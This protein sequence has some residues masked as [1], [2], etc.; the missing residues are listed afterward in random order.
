MAMVTALWLLALL[1]SLTAVALAAAREGLARSRWRTTRVRADP[2]RLTL[3]R[4]DSI[5]LGRGTWCTI[6]AY[7]PAAR[8][9]LNL[10]DSAM[11]RSY[12][13]SDSLVAALLDWRDADDVP[14]R[15]GA[16]RREY[17]ALDRP[18]PRNGALE[19]VSE[20]RLVRGF[21]GWSADSLRSVWTVDGDGR[22]DVNLAPMAMLRTLPWFTAGDLM[23]LDVARARGDRVGDLYSFIALLGVTRRE[24]LAPL[25]PDI[26]HALVTS[27]GALAVE[28]TAG[29]AGQPGVAHNALTVVPQSGRLAVVR[30]VA[31]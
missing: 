25:L 2:A 9:N 29:I 31:W 22:L 10:A 19:G 3:E 26:Q 18:G 20:L 30:R 8:M 21:E 28:V 12:L 4:A 14:R 5:D 27:S 7:S 15:L 1:T 16:E 23:V 13:H 17:R 6:R 24:Q 11:L